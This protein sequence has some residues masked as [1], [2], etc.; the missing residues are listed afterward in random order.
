MSKAQITITLNSKE[1][2]EE[3]SK[4]AKQKGYTLAILAKVALLEWIKRRPPTDKKRYG[5]LLE[6][7]HP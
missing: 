1:L 4:Y 3:L 7:I 2:K 6:R 5:K